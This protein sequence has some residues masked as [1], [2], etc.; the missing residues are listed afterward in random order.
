MIT[1]AMVMKGLAYVGAWTIG[2]KVIYPVANSVGYTL[3][4]G[5]GMMANSI[6]RGT[7]KAKKGKVEKDQ[8]KEQQILA[9]LEEC[10]AKFSEN[11]TKEPDNVV[12]FVEE[13]K[14]EPKFDQKTTDWILK[15]RDQYGGFANVVLE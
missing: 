14:P 8:A 9:L 5:I 1:E 4:R 6:R 7:R 15:C 12:A 3:G 2:K 11:E 13:V 10:N